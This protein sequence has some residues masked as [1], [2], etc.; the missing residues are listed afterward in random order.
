MANLCR[1]PMAQIVA[2]HFAHDAKLKKFCQLESAGLSAG[3]LGE[4]IDP[5]ALAVL[6]RRGYRPAK[7]KSRSIAD[8]DFAK[9]DLILAMDQATLQGLQKRCPPEHRHKPR[10][11]LE[12]APAG[13]PKEIPDPY[14]GPAQGFENVLD[15]CEAG[16][17]GLIAYLKSIA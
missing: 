1:S 11:F 12:F 5:R 15:L 10:L 3:R 2:E 16:S 13:R 8:K 17:R 7:R 6:T 4:P 14:Y 9:F